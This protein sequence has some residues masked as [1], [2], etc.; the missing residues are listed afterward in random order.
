MRRVLAGKLANDQTSC[1][2]A[3][4]VRHRSVFSLFQTV[5]VS[6]SKITGNACFREHVAIDH[7]TGHCARR[8][9]RQWQCADIKRIHRNHVTM[10]LGTNW[11]AWATIPGDAKVG[12]C[13]ERFS[14]LGSLR[15]AGDIRGDVYENPVPPTAIC[16]RVR[17][18]HCDSE[19]L[20]FWRSVTPLQSRRNILPFATQTVKR[21]AQRYYSSILEGRTRHFHCER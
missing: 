19:A 8:G 5:I 9:N 1:R 18:E 2:C 6:A 10:R 17:I 4:R 3:L 15:Q 7:V 11:W 16:R 12:V 20:R 13:R 21:M 14:G